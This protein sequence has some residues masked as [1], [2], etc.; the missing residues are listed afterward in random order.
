MTV[1]AT[2]A[3]RS[4]VRFGQTSSAWW[5][6][7]REGVDGDTTVETPFLDSYVGG[8]GTGRCAEEVFDLWSHL[9]IEPDE[10]P[11]TRHQTRRLAHL[12]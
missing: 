4:K 3:P 8:A 11:F 7:L 6:H 2:P 9:D 1:R 10:P 12:L 5:R